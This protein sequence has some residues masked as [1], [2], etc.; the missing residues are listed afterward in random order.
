MKKRRPSP[1]SARLQRGIALIEVLVSILIFMFGV[2]GLVGMQ[3]AMSR[4][5]TEAKFRADAANLANEGIARMWSD[6]T[7]LASYNGGSCASIA[8]CKEWQDKVQG[9][10]PQGSGAVTLDAS[11]GDAT[12]TVS[13][14]AGGGEPHHYTIATTVAK[15]GS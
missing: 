12:V 5:Q 14:T 3:S 13:W 4:A 8:R 2:L 11:T 15:A 9:A 7:N 10:L 1:V 6:L